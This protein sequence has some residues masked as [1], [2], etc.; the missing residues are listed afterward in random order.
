MDSGRP[1]AQALRIAQTEG[2]RECG[3]EE[4]IWASEGG[5]GEDCIRRGCVI[6]IFY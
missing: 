3:A 6:C 2:V 5:S 4:D 1:S